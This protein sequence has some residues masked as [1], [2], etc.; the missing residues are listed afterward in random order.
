LDKIVQ[1]EYNDTGGAVSKKIITQFD[2]NNKVKEMVSY[3]PSNDIINKQEFI[4]DESGIL[5]TRKI[6]YVTDL[7]NP[8]YIYNYFYDIEGRVIKMIE[9]SNIGTPST[10]T[11]L[12]AYN[13]HIITVTEN[14]TF[15]GTLPGFTF[16]LNDNG[17]IYKKVAG[18]ITDEL[19]YDVDNVIFHGGTS[20][21]PSIHY[22]YDNITQPIGPYINIVKNQY[23][24]INNALIMSGF[25]NISFLG[26]KYLIKRTDSYNSATFLYKYEFNEEGYPV[27]IKYY[28]G[29]DTIP[30]TI[31]EV[32][33]K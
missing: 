15:F 14:S 9:V 32:F 27:K 19:T 24:S 7:V 22:E 13:N 10:S 30:Y 28:F 21:S 17:L 16:E 18:D 25:S 3:N 31:R 20:H 5:K 26:S 6:Y 1:T 12:Y 8:I 11:Y 4:Y 2:D 23:G 33:Y 29:E